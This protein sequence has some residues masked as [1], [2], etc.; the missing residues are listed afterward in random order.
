MFGTRHASF[1]LSF[2][3]SDM[4][5]WHRCRLPHDTPLYKIHRLDQLKGNRINSITLSVAFLNDFIIN[6]KQN[7]KHCRIFPPHNNSNQNIL[8]NVKRAT[9][10]HCECTR[11]LVGSELTVPPSSGSLPL[12]RH[13]TSIG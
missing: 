10:A 12:L 8:K 1:S 11:D 7:Q 2:V 4:T 6:Q 9:I 3:C 5:K 13:K